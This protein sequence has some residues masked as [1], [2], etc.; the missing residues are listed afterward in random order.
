MLAQLRELLVPY[1]HVFVSPT[2]PGLEPALIDL[3][4]VAALADVFAN[5]PDHV[6]PIERITQVVEPTVRRLINRKNVLVGHPG[7]VYRLPAVNPFLDQG[8]ALL[9]GGDY[10]RGGISRRSPSNN[11]A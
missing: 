4:D 3:E 11:G 7:A 6:R 9:A 5:D 2:L 1:A 8:P 10:R